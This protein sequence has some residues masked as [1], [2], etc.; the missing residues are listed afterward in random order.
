MAQRDQPIDEVLGETRDARA[1]ARQSDLL[2]ERKAG[3]ERGQAEEVWRAVLEAGVAR[4]QAVSIRGDRDVL[5][6]AAREPGPAQQ[7][8]RIAARDKSAH[9]GGIA[10]QLVERKDP[11]I[12][13]AFSQAERVAGR[14]CGD[15][16]QDLEAQSARPRH[17]RERMP[18]TREVRLRRHGEE[19]AAVR[20]LVGKP[21]LGVAQAQL[22]IERQHTHRRTGTPGI[23]AHPVHR[24]VVVGGQDQPGARAERI[25]LGD[26][27]DGGGR[28]GSEADVVRRGI[29]VE[30]AEDQSARVLDH[31][32]AGPR[33]R[34]LG[35]RIAEHAVGEERVVGAQLRH[36]GQRA[37]CVVEVGQ[38]QLIQPGELARP[39]RSEVAIERVRG[40]GAGG[41]AQAPHR[42]RSW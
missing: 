36:P 25:A 37:R 24:V 7:R 3:R 41:R 11:E 42:T 16:E 19:P 39:Q 28:V 34:R 4:V 5:D 1:Q 29:D 22:A 26:Q 30:E 18:D 6:R 38:A 35:V 2:E 13:G 20:R 14:V 9:A 10:E 31:R 33:R 15:V 17:Q 23:L 40:R 27:L 8:Q 12:G 21:L 32:A